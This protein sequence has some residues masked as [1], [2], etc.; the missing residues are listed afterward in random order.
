M[1][2]QLNWP[3]RPDTSIFHAAAA[4]SRGKS[5][6]G[7][8]LE[9]A[10]QKPVAE[11]DAFAGACGITAPALWEAICGS[12]VLSDGLG[13]TC[14]LVHRK[15]FGPGVSKTG[16]AEHVRD[17]AMKGR[18]FFQD[19]A[20][21]LQ[22]RKE[23]LE[24]K[25]RPRGN[26]ILVE[27]SRL[28]DERIVAPKA[29]IALVSPMTGGGGAAHLDYN[30]IRLEAVSTDPNPDLPEVVR[31]AWLI[32]QLQSDLP[33]FSETLNRLRVP[34]VSAMALLPPTLEAA[35]RVELVTGPE[36]LMPVAVERWIVHERLSAGQDEAS[37]ADI[38]AQWWS[39]YR[40]RRP[41]WHVALAAL[42]RLLDGVRF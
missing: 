24:M 40:D 36:T 21:E 22:V 32:S 39:T 14:D 18:P 2:C 37:L 5:L 34:L 19:V 3:I 6:I 1:N 13:D 8:N 10:L 31:I 15:A 30:S 4:V 11:F 23:Q 12:S 33:A 17:V 25:W 9:A 26:S 29:D 38:I 27:L 42:D 7:R 20:Q 16:V 28:T 41:P 35:E